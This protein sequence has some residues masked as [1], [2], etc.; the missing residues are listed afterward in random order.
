MQSL[1]IKD[2][3]YNK[4]GLLFAGIFSF[5]QLVKPIL[6]ILLEHDVEVPSRFF[7]FD[8]FYSVGC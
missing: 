7:C 6:F 5:N 2:L 1:K 3:F 8:S 4:K